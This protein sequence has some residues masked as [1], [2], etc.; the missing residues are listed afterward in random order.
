MGNSVCNSHKYAYYIHKYILVFLRNMCTFSISNAW[1]DVNYLATT[2]RNHIPKPKWSGVTDSLIL[3]YK[4]TL[5]CLLNDI[6]IPWDA[7]QCINPQCD[8][9]S[10]HC[11]SIQLFHDSIIDKCLISSELCIPHT[12]DKGHRPSNIAGWNDIVK[13]YKEASIFWH[14]VWKDCGSPRNAAIA[15]VMRRARAQYHKIVKQVKKDQNIIQRDKMAESLL[16]DKGRSFWSE[17]R[18]ISGKCKTIPNMVDGSIGD[19][20]ISDVFAE[21]YKAL[22]NSVSYEN[23]DMDKLLQSVDKIITNECSKLDIPYIAVENVIDAMSRIKRGKN[24]GYGMLYSDHFI[25][26]PHRLYV[27]LTMLFNTMIIHGFSP[28]GFNVS[29]IQPLVKNKR[30]SL[31]ES[32]NYRAIALSS[33]LSKIFDWVILNKNVNQFETS[34]LQYGFKPKS[35]TTQCTFALMETVNYYR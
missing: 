24:D 16:E 13:P 5:D 2:E 3:K 14:N 22:Y 1:I 33:P 21:K 12:S 31:N 29:T 30:K 7:I 11:R 25:N 19:D 4:N 17:I 18:K 9:R 28:D 27:L 15:D 32:S 10:E 23:D 35:S 6:V 34:E 20:N 8:K 26:G